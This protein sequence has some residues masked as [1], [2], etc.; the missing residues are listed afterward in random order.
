MATPDDDE[1]LGLLG[2]RLSGLGYPAAQPVARRLAEDLRDGAPSPSAPALIEA[3]HFR[4]PSALEPLQAAF[5]D[6][7]TPDAGRVELA[8]ALLRL[9]DDESWRDGVAAVLSDERADVSLRLRAAAP[10][11]E[12]MDAR[13]VVELRE[14]IDGLG[15][16]PPAE[17][18]RVIEF[19]AALDLPEARDLLWAAMEEHLAPEVR[20][21]TSRAIGPRLDEPRVTL[22]G[23]EEPPAR[24]PVR[25]APKKEE[26]KADSG[27]MGLQIGAA[28]VVAVA[29]GV[30]LLKRRD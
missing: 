21:A 9:E 25:R 22:V 17:Q 11:F 4:P 29:L 19:L 13:A 6:S 28:V 26:K 24:E 3:L 15:S 2:V 27:T 16:L 20:E 1:A 7:A 23:V 18:A 14:I 10:L 30:W 5:R 12:V 8:N